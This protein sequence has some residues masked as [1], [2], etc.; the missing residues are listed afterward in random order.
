MHLSSSACRFDLQLSTDS[1]V[2][3]G[4]E[5]SHEELEPGQEVEQVGDLGASPDLG[6][7][8]RVTGPKSGDAPR[9]PTC[10]TSCPGSSSSWEGS[11]P[12]ITMESVDNCKS[13]LHA[14][15][16]RCMVKLLLLSKYS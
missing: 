4:E 16:D 10:S 12:K 9:S 6:P 5:P 3:L 14:E 15:D 13:N 1:I 2:I 11:S 8:T 7:V